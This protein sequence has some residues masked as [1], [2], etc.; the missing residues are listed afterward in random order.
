MYLGDM[1][2]GDRG[3]MPR[4]R[5]C[6]FGGWH[7]HI[8]KGRYQGIAAG[9]DGRGPKLPALE[10]EIEIPRVRKLRKRRKKRYRISALGKPLKTSNPPAKTPP[11]SGGLPY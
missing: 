1:N 11:Q 3:S 9:K 8:D 10:F 5:S 7:S 6:W 4:V 2:G